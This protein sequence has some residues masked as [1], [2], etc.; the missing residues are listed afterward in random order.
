MTPYRIVIGTAEY[1]IRG[2]ETWMRNAGSGERF[3]R[4]D[5][6]KCPDTYEQPLVLLDWLWDTELRDTVRETNA[7][8]AKRQRLFAASGTLRD[9]RRCLTGTSNK[10]TIVHTT[11]GVTA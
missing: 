6:G 7:L 11:T 1:E 2:R 3:H 8:D 4:F 9:I 10:V 5:T